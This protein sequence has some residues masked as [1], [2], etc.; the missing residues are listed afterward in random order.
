MITRLKEDEVFQYGDINITTTRDEDDN[1][2]LKIFTDDGFLKVLPQ[3]G[4]SIIVESTQ[5]LSNG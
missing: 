5:K 4:N 1:R 2:V 3:S